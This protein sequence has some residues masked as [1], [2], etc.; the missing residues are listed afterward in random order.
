MAFRNPSG[1]TSATTTVRINSAKTS[2]PSVETPQAVNPADTHIWGVYGLLV[3]LSIIELYSASSFE[4]AKQGL[5][6]PLL[7]HV[8]MLFVGFLIIVGLQRM[9]YRWFVPISRLMFFGSAAAM[10]YVMFFGEYVNG[11]RRTMSLGFMSLQPAEFIKLTT[12]LILAV[13]LSRTQ[14]KK[15]PGLRNR[16]IIY[17]ASVVIGMS[18]LLFTQGLT[19][20]LLL[21]VISMSM[22]LIGAIEWKKFLMVLG[23]YAVVGVAGMGVKMAMSADDDKKSEDLVLV[24]PQGNVFTIAN[25]S[26]AGEGQTSRMTDGTWKNR[27]NNWLGDSVPKYR[28]PITQKNLQ[29]MRSYMAQANGGL[30]GVF[31][32]NS[33][34]TSRLP[35]AFSDYIFAIIVEDLGFIGG[36]AIM[37]LYLWLLARAYYIAARC[38]QAYPAFLVTGMAVM[39]AFQALCHMAI[40][41]GA[42]PVSGQPLPLFSKGGTSILVT[43][44]A[45]GIMLSVSRFA[46]RTDSQRKIQKQ[47]AESL[48]E[49]MRAENPT[50]I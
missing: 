17:A 31:P 50:Q 40:V 37:V 39:I 16:G 2:A 48:P 10:I 34:E 20:T 46:V 24:D 15:S 5:Y 27:I 4:I 32:G 6:A 8:S 11:A 9:H 47:E 21:M 22:M 29:E 38:T 26:A 13:I 49:N 28:Q 35:L 41:S 19:N 7:R 3:V 30:F 1:S 12:V 44:I 36:L 25:T 42:G 23:V 33:R 45:F 14:L 43:S 18:A